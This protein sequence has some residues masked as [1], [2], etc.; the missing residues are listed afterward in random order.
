MPTGQEILSRAAV[1]LNDVDHVRWPLPEKC[2]WLNEGVRAICLAKPSAASMTIV[3][4]LQVGTLQ[5]LPDAI[6][7]SP[8]KPLSLLSVNRNILDANEPRKAGRMVKHTARG[9][10]DVTDPDWHDRSR[11]QF[12]KEVRNYCYND[13]VPLEYYVYPGNDGTGMVEAEIG[14]LPPP[15]A[16]AVDAD[17]AD[18]ASYAVDVGLP[19][20]YSVPLLDYVL[21][22]CQM[23]DDTDGAAGRS[24]VHYQ[25]FATAIGLKIQVEKAHS[26]NARAST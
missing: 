16:I 13:M 14:H 5:K 22:R 21:Y 10:L 7:D 23:K 9:Q 17:P 20:P 15:V 25:Q 3:L 19:E 1:L 2:D 24:A 8:V 4:K 18:L 26:P 11:V 6:L 12:R